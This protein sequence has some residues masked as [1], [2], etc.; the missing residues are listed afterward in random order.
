VTVW[1]YG[2]IWVQSGRR[3]VM[4]LGGGERESLGLV[5]SGQDALETLNRIGADGWELV[6]TEVHPAGEGGGHTVFWLKRPR[7]SADG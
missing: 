1:E 2:Y 6:G 7:P 5:G 4:T 3:G